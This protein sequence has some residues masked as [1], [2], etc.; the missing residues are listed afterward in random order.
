MGMPVDRSALL[1]RLPLPRRQGI[2]S[3]ACATF[4]ESDPRRTSHHDASQNRPASSASAAA[5]RLWRNPGQSGST[6]PD[7]LALHQGALLP[8]LSRVWEARGFSN[9]GTWPE[10]F[11]TDPAAEEVFM[12]CNIDGPWN[13]AEAQDRVADPHVC[14]RGW[15]R[16]RVSRSPHST[17]AAAPWRVCLTSARRAP[18][19]NS[20]TQ[21]SNVADFQGV[22]ELYT[23]SATRCSYLSAPTSRI[24]SGVAHHATLA[25]LLSH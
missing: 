14:T 11:G 20:C 16:N 10:V 23:L 9:A 1:A 24:C 6:L 4:R 15:V 18:H 13:V 22:C 17:Q 19:L 8:E 21:I 7:Y 2:P 3:A 12:A 25:I 5:G